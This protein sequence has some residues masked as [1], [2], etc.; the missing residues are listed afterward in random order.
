MMLEADGGHFWLT[1]MRD[2]PRL[3]APILAQV[4]ASPDELG[5]V[6]E[7][8][9]KDEEL[10]LEERRA[11]PARSPTEPTEEEKAAHSVT[12]VPFRSWCGG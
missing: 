8:P 11:V 10:P 4:A 6:D 2:G 3:V 5:D 7:R 9:S 1:G 12:H